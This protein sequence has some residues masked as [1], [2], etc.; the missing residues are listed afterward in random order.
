MAKIVFSGDVDEANFEPIIN[1]AGGAE[2]DDEDDSWLVS[3]LNIQI[4]ANSDLQVDIDVNLQSHILKDTL[5]DNPKE[6]LVMEEEDISVTTQTE[7]DL[8]FDVTKA[9]FGSFS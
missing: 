4:E 2:D 6:K 3:P 9:E 8:N 1:G 5:A 7:E